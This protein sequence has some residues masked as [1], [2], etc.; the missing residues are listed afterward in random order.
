MYSW[1]DKRVGVESERRPSLTKPFGRRGR[2]ESEA[3]VV[4]PWLGL[5]VGEA[6]QSQKRASSLLG[7]AFWSERQVGV[8]SERRPSLARPSDRRLD[9]PSNLSL[10][11][12][13]SPGV[14]R[15]LQRCLLS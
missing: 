5:S 15:R 9:C 1:S 7:Q 3:S 4:P 12:Q 11:I 6:G 13:A 10:G 14:A 8:E 2:P